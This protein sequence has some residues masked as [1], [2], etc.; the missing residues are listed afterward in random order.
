[1][2]CKINALNNHVAMDNNTLLLANGKTDQEGTRDL[3]KI[4]PLNKSHYEK[5]MFQRENSVEGITFKPIDL[6]VLSEEGKMLKLA[7][8]N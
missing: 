5:N 8:Y 2:F 3:L 6:S 7:L 1:M 4:R